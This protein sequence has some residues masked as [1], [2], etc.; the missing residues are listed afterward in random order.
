MKPLNILNHYWKQHVNIC[1]RHTT[2]Y[3]SDHYRTRDRCLSWCFI[4]RACGARTRYLEPK[5]DPLLTLTKCF[6]LPNPTSKAWG[7]GLR[8]GQTEP[9]LY[10]YSCSCVPICGRAS[11]DLTESSRT[12]DELDCVVILF[13]FGRIDSAWG[14]S[15]RVVVRRETGQAETSL[16]W[17]LTHHDKMSCW[18]Q[19]E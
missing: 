18:L 17:H 11:C 10:I 15:Q 19:E 7:A 8:S 12:D 6:L 4:I 9:N 5:H 14:V 13:C 3:M 2:E 16:R 1:Q